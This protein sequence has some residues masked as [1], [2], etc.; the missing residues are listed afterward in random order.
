MSKRV[1]VTG[2][3]GFIG[4]EVVKQLSA[5]GYAV[6]VIDD[7]SKPES[8]APEAPGPGS[9]EF[10]KRDLTD[11]KATKEAFADH[12]VCVHL[13]AKIGGIGYFHRFPATILAENDKLYASVFGACAELNY[14][15]ILYVSSSMVF[16]NAVVFPSSEEHILT[17]PVPRSAYGFSKLSGEWY[18]RSFAEQ[19]DLDFSIVRPFNAYGVNEAPGNEVGYAH[20]I[21]DLAWKILDGQNPLEILGNGEQTRC[22]THVS[23][24]AR[25]I[26][27]VL[28]HPAARNQDFNISSSEEAKVLDLA[29]MI[30]KHYLPDS[31]PSFKHIDPFRDDVQRRIPSVE[32]AKTMLGYTAEV[33][34]EAGL[35]EVLEWLRVRHAEERGK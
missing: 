18:C 16:E 29:N 31:E 5:K 6:R 12:D 9:V 2:G 19:Y 17:T 26:V 1:I 11:P 25:G 10:L 8:A 34:L 32:K 20:V 30:W 7:L 14:D 3:C 24:I 4:R 22:F 23:D 15:R 21:P 13:A 27:T 35:A 33:T 28:E